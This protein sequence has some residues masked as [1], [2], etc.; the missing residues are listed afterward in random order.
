MTQKTLIK[1]ILLNVFVLPGAGHAVF[2]KKLRGAA[3]GAAILLL[4]V[5]M[6]IHVSSATFDAM[7]SVPADSAQMSEVMALSQS[8]T[9]NVMADLAP[10]INV[11]LWLFILL[12][13]ASVV[14]LFFIYK[15]QKEQTR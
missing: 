4:L 13:L 2:K 5:I 8:L 3:F 12:Y 7:N 6:V 11:Y 10:A 9:S 15:K 14:D 1:A